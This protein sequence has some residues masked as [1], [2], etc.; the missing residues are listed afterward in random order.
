MKIVHEQI[1]FDCLAQF[2]A[3]VS[4]E[5]LMAQ[6]PQAAAEIEKFLAVAA[7]LQQVKVQPSLAARQQSQKL[8][9]QQAAE[10]RAAGRRGWFSWRGCSVRCCH[11]PLWLW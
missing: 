2:E 3:G 4:A 10:M 5:A 8:F 7:Q 9:L 6:Y 1:L 11:W